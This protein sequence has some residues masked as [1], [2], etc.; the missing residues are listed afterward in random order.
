M[1]R[2]LN[3]NNKKR[4]WLVWV[5]LLFFPPVGI[6]LLWKKTEWSKKKKGIL[7][8]AAALFFFSP[9][10]IV[11]AEPLPLYESRTEFVEAFQTTNEELGFSFELTNSV[12][13]KNVTTSTLYPGVSLIENSDKNGKIHELVVVG[14]GEGTDSILGISTLIGTTL[15]DATTEEIAGVLQDLRLFDDTFDFKK[16]ESV[17]EK[18]LIRYELRYEEKKGIILSISRVQ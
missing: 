4:N 15:P 18:N 12:K 5:F 17:V 9:F 14:Q 16:E 3:K 8:A 1:Q 7:T 13:E 6:F 10:A 11:S 2:S